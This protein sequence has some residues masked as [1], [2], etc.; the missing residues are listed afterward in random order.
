MNGS[1]KMI[2][3]KLTLTK[4]I[5]LVKKQVE[6]KSS[7]ERYIFEKEFKEIYKLCKK[8][9]FKKIKDKLKSWLIMMKKYLKKIK[10]S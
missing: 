3:K 2:S 9:I 4:I 8:S 10:K 5:Q 1:K 7:I 6:L